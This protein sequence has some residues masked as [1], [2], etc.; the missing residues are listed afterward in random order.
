[1]ESIRKFEIGKTYKTRSIGDHNCIYL[2]TVTKRTAKTI[3]IDTRSEGIV[4]R[5][6]KIWNG[7][8]TIKPFGSYSMAPMF[9]ANKERIL[10]D[11][12]L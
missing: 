4:V 10:R 2:G 7:I 6:I 3:T 12:L 11:E 8:E 5:R 9:S 1:M